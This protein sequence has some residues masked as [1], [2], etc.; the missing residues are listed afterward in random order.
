M[1]ALPLFSHRGFGV[2]G[3]FSDGCPVTIGTSLLTQ[4]ESISTRE[5]G[6]VTMEECIF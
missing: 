2:V 4:D 1:L 6:R 5:C 3:V